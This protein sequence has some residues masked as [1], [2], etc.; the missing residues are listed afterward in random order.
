[1]PTNNFKLF[2]ENKSN[3]MSSQEYASSVARSSGV[4]SGI[5]SSQLHNK[6][7]YQLSLM[8][9]AL[10]QLMNANGI[11]ASDEVAVSSF[12]AN[13]SS[14]LLQKEVDKASSAQAI[15]AV[16]N[17]K[18]M[19]PYLVKQM[20]DEYTA[21]ATVNVS[22]RE[23]AVVTITHTN[24]SKS[25]TATAGATEIATFHPNLLGDYTA[26]A[27]IEG[28][29]FNG[30][31]TLENIGILNV[32]S[33]ITLDNITW[34]NLSTLSNSGNA[35][36]VFAVGDSK[37]FTYNNVDYTAVIAG[38]NHDA[39]SGGGTAGI[40]FVMG[41]CLPN[42]YSTSGPGWT[43]SSIRTTV[44]PSVVA[45]FP[46]DLKNAVKTVTKYTSIGSKSS[47]ITDTQDDF[48]LFSEV[49]L[50][51]GA[52]HS[53][54]GEGTAYPL[55]TDNDSRKR[56]RWYSSS[57]QNAAWWTRSPTINYNTYFV[58]V[59]N[60]GA[61]NTLEPSDNSTCVCLGFCV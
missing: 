56:K 47:T 49:E 42:Y 2:D 52:T 7:M 12:V 43:N 4:Q 58:Y 13:L 14:T 28:Q 21:N 25:W 36:N 3:M 9:Y 60:S 15:A 41:Q 61:F 29:T 46:S 45:D 16:D 33:F 59:M 35:A 53:F 31:F 20:I 24:T 39:I 50:G 23:N 26:T 22:A 1:M 8:V 51:G 17:T 54:S 18:W 19:T 57:W 32:P 5:A 10:S 30:S 40:T 44:I 34:A 48:W 38:F 11:D 6:S 55:F 37:T 27:V